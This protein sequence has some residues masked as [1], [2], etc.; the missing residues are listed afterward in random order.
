MRDFGA[1]LKN[2]F[3]LLS[4][5]VVNHMESWVWDDAVT[6]L[7]SATLLFQSWLLVQR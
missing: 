2:S 5:V 4:A 1:A 3:T 6:V 7:C